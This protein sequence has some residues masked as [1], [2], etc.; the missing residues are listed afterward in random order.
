LITAFGPAGLDEVADADV[1]RLLLV[2]RALVV[3]AVVVVVVGGV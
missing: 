1:G 2:V 3:V